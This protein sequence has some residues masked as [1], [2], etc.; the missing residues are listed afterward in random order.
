MNQPL[1][2]IL[3]SLL[4]LLVLALDLWIVG[5]RHAVKFREGLAWSLIW[6]FL[7]AGFALLLYFRYGRGTAMEFSAA[8][9]VEFSL[10]VDNLFIFFLLFRYFRVPAHL[11]H[12]LLSWGILGVL[13]MRAAFILLG[14]ELIRMFH[15][16]LYAFGGFLIASGVQLF[17]QR[18]VGMEVERNP[19]LRWFRRWIPVTEDYEGEKL[20]VRRRGLYA[21]PLLLV[22][23]VVETTDLLLAT[24][25]IP[26]V[27]AITLNPFIVYTSNVFAVLG[28]RSLFFVVAGMMEVFVY[29]HYGLSLALIFIGA[30]M[31]SADYYPIPTGPS[32]AIVVGLLAISVLASLLRSA[33]RR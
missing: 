21:T 25:S 28:L 24:D 31:L 9:L 18:K 33:P 16:V 6:I 17:R 20:L 4:A 8:Y 11:Q 3:F 32:L 30:K 2:W 22:L 7:A 26:A 15:W 5:R 12:K 13:L 1:F 19:A 14:L 10:S 29:L 23:L 27:F